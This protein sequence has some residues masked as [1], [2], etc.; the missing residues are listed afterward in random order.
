MPQAKDHFGRAT[1][2]V[3][4]WKQRFLR[5]EGPPVRRPGLTAGIRFRMKIECRR[6][7]TIE[8]P[9]AAPSAL[10][11]SAIPIPALRPGL[12][13]AG[14]SGLNDNKITLAGTKSRFPV[15]ICAPRNLDNIRLRSMRQNLCRSVK[16]SKTHGR[17]KSTTSP[18]GADEFSRGSKLHIGVVA[19]LVAQ[20]CGRPISIVV[21][22]I[23]HD[24]VFK[25]AQLPIQAPPH[26]FGIASRKIHTTAGAHKQSVP[27]D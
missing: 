24:V 13:I 14:P 10:H 8:F 5:P 17:S 22:R 2:F 9:G 3:G 27:G 18:H 1:S 12:F 20:R 26:L 7:C 11:L 23:K 4:V 25:S 19:L 15:L 6:R 21:P 16:D